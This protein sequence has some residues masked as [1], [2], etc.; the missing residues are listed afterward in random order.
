[1]S[2]HTGHQEHLTL[3]LATGTVVVWPDVDIGPIC[4]LEVAVA[5]VVVLVDAVAV[6]V[7]VPLPS[8]NGLAERSGK[9]ISV[10]RSLS[11][12]VNPFSVRRPRRVID[13]LIFHLL[14]PGLISVG[15]FGNIETEAFTRIHI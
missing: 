4:I 5:F 9:D 3:L 15:C 1:M 2:L 12:A 7:P 8:D 11:N 6:D 10:R 14:I 13:W